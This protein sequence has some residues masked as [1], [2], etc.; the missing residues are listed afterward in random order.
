MGQVRPERTPLSDTEQGDS[1]RAR[2]YLLRC[3]AS[4]YVGDDWTDEDV[5][6]FADLPRVF[7]IRVGPSARSR[8]RYCLRSQGEVDELLRLLA[9][10]R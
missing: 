1:P 2:R 4:L 6:A 8:A 7:S 9:D 5:F 3:D 10:L